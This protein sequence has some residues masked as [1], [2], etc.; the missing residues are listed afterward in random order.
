MCVY[1]RTLV[2]ICI[3]MYMYVYPQLMEYKV[4]W[5]ESQA[6]LQQLLKSA[7]KVS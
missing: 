6:E 1:I 4:K 3:Y 7:K 5:G 2:Y